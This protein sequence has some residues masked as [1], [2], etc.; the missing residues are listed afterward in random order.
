MTNRMWMVRAGEGGFKIDDFLQNNQISI[1]W[2]QV[3][4]LSRFKNQEDLKQEL[5]TAFPKY[6]Q[7]KIN[8]TVGQINRF[9]F[10]FARGDT[11]VTYNSRDRVYHVGE[12][13]SDYQYNTKGGEHPH[14]RQVRWYGEVRRDILST[15]TKNS[16]GSIATIFEVNEDAKDEVLR[17][18]GSKENKIIEKKE[19]VEELEELREDMISK[20]FEFIKDKT[21]S[22]DWEEMQDLVAG[23][24]RAMGYKTIVSPRGADR[25]KD[26]KASPDGLGLEDPRIIAEVKHREGPMG[27]K[28]IRSFIGVLQEG[29]K[30]L[31]VSTGGFSKDAKYEAE[32]SQ[33]PLTLI[34]ADMLV[35]LIIQYYDKFDSEARTL[36]SLTKIYWPV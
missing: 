3:G 22:L 18:V 35:D 7:G 28:E 32:R 11:V 8:M 15:S 5:S 20:A 30:G 23:L 36:V 31:Y 25:G 24:L 13:I 26:I 4:D 21:L 1:G 19:E 6:N 2:S 10:V 29:N 14:I 17:L 33:K 16:M 27:S 9:R 12:I 34:D